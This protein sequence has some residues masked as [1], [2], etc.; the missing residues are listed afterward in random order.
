M[1]HLLADDDGLVLFRRVLAADPHRLIVLRP[2]NVGS[3]EQSQVDVSAIIGR[4]P[5]C[6]LS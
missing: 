4:I 2:A 6:M 3:C 1:N 5:S